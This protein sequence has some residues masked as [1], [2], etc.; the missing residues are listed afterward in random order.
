MLVPF[1]LVVIV[2]LLAASVY[3]DLI[4]NKIRNMWVGVATLLGLLAHFYLAGWP[5][6]FS[7]FLGLIVGLGVFLPFYILGGMAAGDVKLM[8]SVGALVGAKLAWIT[9]VLSL[10]SGVLLALGYLAVRGDL[11]RYLSR[12]RLILKNLLVTRKIRLSYLSPEDNEIATHRFPYALAI[13]SGVILSLLLFMTRLPNY[14]L[15]TY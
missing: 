4:Y 7:S 9:V 6:L 12:Y 5:G 15:T 10:L 2:S 1:F 8:A 11:N 14:M 13:A 3:S